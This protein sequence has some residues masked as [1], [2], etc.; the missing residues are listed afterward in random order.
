MSVNDEKGEGLNL[1][2]LT[3]LS[4]IQKT[5]LLE[6]TDSFQQFY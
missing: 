6:Q 4:E 3:K 5:L 2:Q 1:S